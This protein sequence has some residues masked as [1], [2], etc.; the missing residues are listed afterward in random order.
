MHIPVVAGAYPQP[1]LRG[2]TSVV[3]IRHALA[4]RIAGQVHGVVNSK[5]A[6]RNYIVVGEAFAP[7]HVHVARP[8]PRDCLAGVRTEHRVLGDQR[9]IEVDRECGDALRKRVGELGQRY[10]GVPPV[11]FTTYAATSAICW[12]D[13]VPLNDGIWPLPSVTRAVARR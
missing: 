4:A 13:R 5:A 7:D 2:R 3:S 12:S 9:P 6:V 8:Y 11:A 10:G 1:F